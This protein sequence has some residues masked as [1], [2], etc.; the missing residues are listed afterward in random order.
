M[1]TMFPSLEFFNALKDQ[2]SAD[3]DATLKVEPSE[4]YCG[5]AIGDML[6]VVEFDGRECAA[7]VHGGN[8]LDLDFILS[9]PREVWESAVAAI[10]AD[11][12]GSQGNL[13]DLIEQGAIE[14]RSEVED[15]PEQAKAAL[16]FIQAFFELARRFDVKFA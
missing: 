8:P 4:A 10:V 13:A 11:V 1:S 9:A 5:F 3:P 6:V 14:I 12:A 16:G 15:G 7:V 2:L